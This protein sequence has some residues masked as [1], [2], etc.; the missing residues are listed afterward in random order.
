MPDSAGVSR[1]DGAG[2][3]DWEHVAQS[4]AVILTTPIGSRIMRRDFGSELFD[5]ID[6]KMTP[7]TILAIYGAAAVAI[8]R[9]EPRFRVEQAAIIEADPGGRIRL[10]LAGVFFPRGHRGDFTRSESATVSVILPRAGA[11]T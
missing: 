6:A 3:S 10:A 7:R 8:A 2:R 4:I 9:W 5:L 1:I 11:A